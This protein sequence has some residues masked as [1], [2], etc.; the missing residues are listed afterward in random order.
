M[1]PRLH[2]TLRLGGPL[3]LPSGAGQGGARSRILGACCFL[4]FMEAMT[5]TAQQRLVMP[6]NAEADAAT[7][8]RC[9]KLAKQNPATAQKL[10]SAWHER[11]GAHPADHCAAVA[12]NGL[13]QYKEAA[14]RLEALAQ[15]MTTAPTALRAEVFDQAGQAWGLAGDP[16]RAYAAAGTAVTLL[17]NDTDLL[18]DRAQA[19][20][21][22]GYFDKAVDDLD[23]VLKAN[24]DPCRRVDLPCRRKS[25]SR[26]FGFRIGGYREGGRQGAGFSSSSAGAW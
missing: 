12:L 18:I 10:A 1:N 14:I 13:K 4:L 20:A 17:P 9:M 21:S 3:V 25:R 15:S 16:A 22:A 8:E 7:Y 23:H 6:R 26:S 2:P 24:P 19:A 11:G 5:A